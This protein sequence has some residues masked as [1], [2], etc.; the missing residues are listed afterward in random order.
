MLTIPSRSRFEATITLR[1]DSYDATPAAGGTVR[2]ASAGGVLGIEQLTPGTTIGA[3]DGA[4]GNLQWSAAEI[5]QVQGFSLVRLGNAASG[6]VDVRPPW[7]PFPVERP[8]AS[9]S[10]Q[11]QRLDTVF[12]VIQE[13]PQDDADAAGFA[14]R[15]GRSTSRMRFVIEGFD[16]ERKK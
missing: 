5:G 7:F 10:A 8:P 13:W 14:A 4:I 15:P 1:G 3:G 12:A 6:A 11:Q 16:D 2:I 9:R